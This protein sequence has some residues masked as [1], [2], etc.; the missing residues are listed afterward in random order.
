M[1]PGALA[2][3]LSP[4]LSVPVAMMRAPVD[5]GETRPLAW[6]LAQLARLQALLV[7]AGEPL[8]QALARDLGKPPLEAGLE[9]VAV[10]QE[11]RHT[12][13]QLRRW[14]AP[15]P[16]PLPLWALPA[17][18]WQQ[19][20][21]LGCVLIIGPW[22]YPFQLSLHPL[23][24]ALAAGNSCVIK[25]S[26]HAP[27]CAALI[28]ELVARHFPAE[29]VQVV[30]GG[31][32]VA[33]R[34]LQER[35]DHI[36]YTGGGRVGRLVLAAA[37]PHLTPVTLELGG[38][39]PAIVIEGADLSVSGRRIAWGKS[40]NAG[41]T[42]V[43]PDH[44]LVTP[45]LRQPLIEA[46]ASAWRQFHGEDP[47]SSSDYGSIVNEGH[48]RRLEGLLAEARRR[49]QVLIGGRSDASTRRIEPTLLAVDDPDGDPLLQEEL[50]GPLLPLITVPSLERALERVRRGA[51]PL[52][53]YLFG[54]DR[55][56][57]R[58]LQQTSSSGMVTYNDVVLQA[59][60]VTLPFGGV[61]ASGMGTYHGESGFLTFSHLRSLLSRPFRLD[62]PFRYPP[63]RLSPDLLRRLLR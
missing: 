49:G 9:L 27:H 37:A 54:G 33:E 1:S 44:L 48:F 13:R 32:A 31:Q 58:L 36:L 45:A 55:R 3:P 7:D 39:C 22:N 53:I 11:L 47:L 35:F 19:A 24:S 57:R 41:Q 15:R 5:R 25:P 40:I 23:V 17:R 14:M 59:G 29:V 6:R 42:C 8:Q 10:E 18:A 30:T 60:L 63:Y 21:P 2:T 43:A 46:I 12:R 16:R 50:F 52:A 34:L 38:Q 4:P 62:L 56:A 61:G 20:E 26:E 28:A 51:K